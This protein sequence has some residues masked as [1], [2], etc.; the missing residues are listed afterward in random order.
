MYKCFFILAFLFIGLS[1]ANA[2]DI[3]FTRNGNISFHAGT[4]LEDIDGINNDVASLINA[5]TGDIAFTVL[6]KSFHFTRSLMEEHFNENYMEST[7]FPKST[8]SGKIT[9]PGKVNF[10]KDGTYPVS[11]EGDLSIHGVTKKITAPATIKII[12]GKIS[13]EAKFKILMSDYNVA[14]PGVVADKIS[15]EAMVEVKCNYEKKN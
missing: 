8:F 11:V 7:K 2:Q 10:V 14:I 5:K 12:G 3:W 6:V 9:D 15:K 13:A 1:H 4:S